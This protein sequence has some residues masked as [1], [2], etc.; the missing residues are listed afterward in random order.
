MTLLNSI[1]LWNHVKYGKLLAKGLVS[2]KRYN[3]LRINNRKQLFIYLQSYDIFG[4]DNETYLMEYWISSSGNNVKKFV[5][6]I[7]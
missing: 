5:L 1:Y 6:T 2:L 4:F 3:F 7:F